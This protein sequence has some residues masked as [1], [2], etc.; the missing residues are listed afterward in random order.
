MLNQLV[1]KLCDGLHINMLHVHVITQND[2]TLFLYL[3]DHQVVEISDHRV[4]MR[5]EDVV[6]IDAPCDYT[7]KDALL[8]LTDG[9]QQIVPR[10]HFDEMANSTP[11]EA[12]GPAEDFP[13]RID[14]R[15][16]AAAAITDNNA[17]Q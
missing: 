13:P 7:V 9:C 3:P 14:W 1:I 17:S 2:E 11:P 4:V 16:R 15:K 12:A 5:S 8:E 6:V 10:F